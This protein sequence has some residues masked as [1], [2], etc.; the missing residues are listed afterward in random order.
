MGTT[1]KY[2]LRNKSGETMKTVEA[3]SL[4]KA[5][6]FFAKIKNLDRKTLLR[7]FIV[8]VVS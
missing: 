1:K 6:V 3:A 7:L 2:A 8:G 4:K 5:E